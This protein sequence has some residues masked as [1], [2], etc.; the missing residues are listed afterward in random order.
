MENILS[1]FPGCPHPLQIRLLKELESKWNSYDVFVITAPTASGKSFI[2]KA[3]ANWAGGTSII[4]PD[5]V[6]LEQYHD[7]FPD[8][9]VLRKRGSY[10]C[11]TYPERT[12]EETHRRLKRCCAG[13]LC[14]YK[15]AC[16][17]SKTL[18][19]SVVANYY[20]YMVHR[21]YKPVLI[22][23]EA[24]K[25]IHMLQDMAAKRIWRYQY[26]WP[27]SIRSL[28]D[29]LDWVST[30]DV[31]KDKKLR[32]LKKE[33]ESTSPATL[34][35]RTR[36]LWRGK[37]ERELLKLIPLDTR[38]EPPTLWPPNKVRK[39]VLMSATIAKPDID[40]MG[41]GK[42]RVCYLEIGSSIPVESR[43]VIYRPIANMSY[44]CQD[45][46]IPTM[47]RYI[48]QLLTENPDKGILHCPYSVASKLEFVLG[49]EDRLIF[50][51]RENKMDVLDD[52]L[53][54]EPEDGYVLVSSGLYEGLDLKN[55]LARWQAI[56]KVPYPSLADPAIRAKMEQ[57]EEWY[58]WQTAKTIIQ[59]S[60]R[61]CRSP[62]DTGY[63]F[64]LD[65]QF[66]NLYTKSYDL[67]P[68]WFRDSVLEENK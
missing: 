38:D 35:Q 36:E 34:V 10:Q 32:K 11:V 12:C 42:K 8:M 19:T 46:S 59:G 63:T 18:T 22:V 65:S 29:I 49:D 31:S 51:N 23:D 58:Q 33:I 28:G 14:S 4:V 25:L 61:I 1:S 47:A 37:E 9:A 50:H 40:N 66:K 13:S 6:L 3:I 55:D 26:G 62:T 54:S 67:F 56:L 5:N 39:I 43:P 2:S 68:K 45:T 27:T 52:W 57:E 64:L 20:T 60:G 17:R 24:H 7:M 30:L 21:L 41:L 16:M 15:K 48:K 44:R 53:Q